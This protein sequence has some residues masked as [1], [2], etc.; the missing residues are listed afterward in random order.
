[1]VGLAILSPGEA[2]G[3]AAGVTVAGGEVGLR[4][5]P[6]G[7]AKSSTSPGQDSS[8]GTGTSSR[9]WQQLGRLQLLSRQMGG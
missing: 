2:G 4:A 7:D 9:R 3:G 5:E 6:A 1:M 8:S